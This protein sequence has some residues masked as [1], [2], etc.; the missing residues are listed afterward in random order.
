MIRL[1]PPLLTMLLISGVQADDVT[2][3]YDR[4]RGE[5]ERDK[6]DFNDSLVDPWKEQRGAIPAVS[7]Q[8]LKK[9]E[10][11][12]GPIDAS[13]YLD[14]ESIQVNK[15]DR[16][17]RYW[18]AIKSGGRISSLNYEGL[19]CSTGEYRNYAYASPRSS[20]QITPLKNSRWRSVKQGGSRNFHRELADNYFCSSGAP[21]TPDGIRA[22]LGGSY[23]LHTPYSQIIDYNE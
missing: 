10:L 12:Q 5:N 15:A 21:R 13:L 18:I 19:R 1:L 7:L 8:A 2:D 20:E 4:F 17:V 6:F 22:S 9:L 14:V 11:S 3:P 16:V 23:Q